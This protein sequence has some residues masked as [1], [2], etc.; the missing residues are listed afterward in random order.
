M[1]KIATKAIA[2]MLVGGMLSSCTNEAGQAN[3][4]QL[5]GLA[6]AIGGG[7]IGSNV[8]KG[9]GRTAG[10]IGGTI[11]GGLIGSEV[12]KSLDKADIAYHNRAQQQAF[13]YNKAGAS[14][15]WKNPDTGASGAITPTKTFE[16]NGNY[17]RE[18][19]QNISVGGK[20]EKAYGTACRQ[21]DGSWEIQ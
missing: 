4:Q 15:T 1:F 5:V 7:V 18:Y 8:G 14:S 19:T 6:G 13:E 21:P 10:I 9:K 11:I 12:G 3:K 16:K 17:C 2:L 20:A